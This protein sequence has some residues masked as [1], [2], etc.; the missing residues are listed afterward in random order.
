MLPVAV[1]AA[2]ANPGTVFVLD[3]LG[4]AETGSGGVDADWAAQLRAFARQP[5]TVAKLSGLLGDIVPAGIEASAK[6]LRPWRDVALAAFGPARLMFGSDWP[7]CT[8]TASYEEVV[9][10]AREL[11]SDLN[12][13]EQAAVLAGTAQRVYRIGATA[14]GTRQ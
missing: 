12:P 1:S 4:N 13:A 7:V 14:P 6:R 9:A 5:N 11:V 2:A 3:H 10:V 8:L